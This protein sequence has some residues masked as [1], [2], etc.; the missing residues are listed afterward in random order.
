MSFARE[1]ESCILQRSH[2]PNISQ[3]AAR[4]L[5]VQ[6]AAKRPHC[7]ML[8]KNSE[9]QFRPVKTR[10]VVLFASLLIALISPPKG[11]S[12]LFTVSFTV[13]KTRILEQSSPATPVPASP[14]AYLFEAVA[15]GLLYDV[16][17]G[18]FTP[19]GNPPLFLAPSPD[20]TYFLSTTY[21]PDESALQTAF[22]NGNYAATIQTNVGPVPVTLAFPAHT[23]PNAPTVTNFNEAQAICAEK[24]FQL[25]WTP[26]SGAGAGDF[27]AVGISDTDGNV[28]L[29]PS[30]LST[31]T[32]SIQIPANLLAPNRSYHAD[33]VFF[34]VLNSVEGFFSPSTLSA[35]ATSNFIPLKTLST[36][37]R[38]EI[39]PKTVA[40]YFNF[41]FTS[42][43]GRS[44][45][46]QTSPNLVSWTSAQTV[47]ANDC[48]TVFVDSQSLGLPRRFYK[49]ISH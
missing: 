22:P 3:V 49:V 6:T 38:V 40:G 43:V 47:T 27:V 2:G 36:E 28:V 31:G 34:H 13:A 15:Q 17:G 35:V 20:G 8:M 46:I 39:L 9:S 10:L 33:I 18:S 4:F 21:M 32:T 30:Q 25:N 29:A 11:Y 24:N 48:L 23:Y 26:F 12:Q 14:A 16:T 1:F 41:R 5:F 7:G 45:E 37:V 44:Y 19:P 42:E